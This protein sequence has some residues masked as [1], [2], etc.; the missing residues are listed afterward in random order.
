M[1]S[2]IDLRPPTAAVYHPHPLSDAAKIVHLLPSERPHEAHPHGLEA[3]KHDIPPV[4]APLE[5]SLRHGW[6]KARARARGRSARAAASCLAADAGQPRLQV[7]ASNSAARPPLT[8]PP[9]TPPPT[10]PPPPPPA[11]ASQPDLAPPEA[12]QLAKPPEIDEADEAARLLDAP[13]VAPESPRDDPYGL[14]PPPPPGEPPRPAHIV[15]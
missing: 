6:P 5:A 7:G 3:L 10:P 11:R 4:K 13:R 9:P 8:P 12:L 15:I 2:H 14:L 1:S